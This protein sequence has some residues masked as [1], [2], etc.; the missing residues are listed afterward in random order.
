[1]LCIICEKCLLNTGK[2][3][4]AVKKQQSKIRGLPLLGNLGSFYAKL[5]KNN[6]SG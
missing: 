1:M 2:G 4:G 5:Q 6:Y 3:N